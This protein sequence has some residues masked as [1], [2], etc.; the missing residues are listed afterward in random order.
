[1]IDIANKGLGANEEGSFKRA[2]KEE[3]E[4]DFESQLIEIATEAEQII[5]ARN[6]SI[7][8]NGQINGNNQQYVDMQ[9]QLRDYENESKKQQVYITNEQTN[10]PIANIE[11]VQYPDGKIASSINAGTDK[12][13]LCILLYQGEL[14]MANCCRRSK[15]KKFQ[16]I[17]L[18]I[19]SLARQKPS[20]CK[21]VHDRL[22]IKLN[23]P[24]FVH[25]AV[26]QDKDIKR[27][28]QKRRCFQRKRARIW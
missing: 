5:S 13:Q 16:Q 10:L 15:N 20:L 12:T 1:M 6:M 11:T 8:G 28:S 23:I 18:K 24:L 25:R 3:V 27:R 17:G 9:T 21:T 22:I 2:D 4:N 19:N 14:R 26:M 7:V